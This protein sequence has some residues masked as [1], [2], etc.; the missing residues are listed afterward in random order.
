MRTKNEHARLGT[1]LPGLWVVGI[2]PPCGQQHPSDLS[3][4]REENSDDKDEAMQATADNTR[5]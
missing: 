2:M 5:L 3:H 1:A 4:S